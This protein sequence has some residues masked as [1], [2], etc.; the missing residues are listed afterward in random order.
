[1]TKQEAVQKHRDMWNWIAD[2][3][4]EHERGE[5]SNCTLG[6]LISVYD[7]KCKYLRDV[8]D[9]EDHEMPFH[10][11]F[12]CEYDSIESFS[13]C[14]RCPVLWGNEEDKNIYNVGFYCERSGSPYMNVVNAAKH[15]DF[16]NAAKFARIVANLPERKDKEHEE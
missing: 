5:E 8:L 16:S 4:E 3:Y 9:M 14:T 6:D 1:M 7:M 11:C 12:C 15:A 10:K 13:K 2:R